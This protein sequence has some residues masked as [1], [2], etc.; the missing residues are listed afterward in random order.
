[1]SPWAVGMALGTCPEV[2]QPEVELAETK[3]AS[4]CSDNKEASPLGLGLDVSGRI[5][6]CPAVTM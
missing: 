4:L 2:L 1:M 6:E 5:S 3:I